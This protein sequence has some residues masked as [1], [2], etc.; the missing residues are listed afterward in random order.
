MFTLKIFKLLVI[1]F[2]ILVILF[3]MYDLKNLATFWNGY[4]SV[5]R[6]EKTGNI[7]RQILLR[8]QKFICGNLMKLISLGSLNLSLVVEDSV[9]FLLRASWTIVC[10]MPETYICL[11]VESTSK[12]FLSYKKC[13]NVLNSKFVNIYVICEQVLPFPLFKFSSI[14]LLIQGNLII[15]FNF[16]VQIKGWEKKCD[17]LLNKSQC[18]PSNQHNYHFS[19]Y[20]EKAF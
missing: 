13:L 4:L 5:K 15:F 3:V 7:S 8:N 17:F 2:L 18:K 12:R 20:T 10:Y 14:T 19:K 16:W 1:L 11:K 6:E 9:W